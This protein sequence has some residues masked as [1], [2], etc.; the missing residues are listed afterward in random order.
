MISTSDTVLITAGYCLFNLAILL[1]S[2]IPQSDAAP[3]SYDQSQT[4]KFNLD[5]KLDNF[6][7]VFFDTINS[8]LLNK[9]AL[10][11]LQFRSVAS[12][13]NVAPE[14]TSEKPLE[15][16]IYETGDEHG[17]RDPYH[18][19]IV[20]IEK[21]GEAGPKSKDPE[22]LG[23]VELNSGAKVE[24]GAAPK[25]LEGGS[26]PEVTIDG[27]KP[28]KRARSLWRNEDSH[29]VV[30]GPGR[31]SKQLGAEDSMKNLDQSDDLAVKEEASKAT[32]P[33]MSLKKQLSKKQEEDLSMSEERNELGTKSDELVLLGYGIENCGPGRYRDQTGI[34]QNDKEFN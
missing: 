14:E 17:G 10:Q 33:G 25:G 28:G 7:I 23:T 1:G 3:T 34:C 22:E 11:A 21:E 24:Q 6:F 9:L 29:R 32:K 19:E 4:G 15:A 12:R 13:H 30:H 27:K 18:V 2:T 20:R 5:A 26:S 16:T 31:G 8:D